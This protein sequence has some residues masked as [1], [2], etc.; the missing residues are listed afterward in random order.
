MSLIDI[1]RRTTL[2]IVVGMLAGGAYA[3]APQAV[4]PAKAPRGGGVDGPFFPSK[5][6]APVLPTTGDALDA[7]AQA[8][9]E[10]QMNANSVL[11]NGAAITKAQA[12][13]NGLG[14]IANHFEEIDRARSGR[15]TLDDVQQYVK[16]RQQ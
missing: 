4:A 6:V 7:Q 16:A 1:V 11:S 13:S 15:V 14:F 9:I 12:Q 3:A 2:S 5:R 8:R 10:K